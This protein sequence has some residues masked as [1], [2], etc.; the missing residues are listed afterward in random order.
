MPFQNK[1]GAKIMSNICFVMQ[2]SIWVISHE[3]KIVRGNT[4]WF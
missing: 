4:A 1:V 3:V 2:C